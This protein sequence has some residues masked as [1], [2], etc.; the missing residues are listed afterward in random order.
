[1]NE[2]LKKRLRGIQDGLMAH[3]Q[4]TSSLPTAAIG[5]EREVLVREF[6]EKVFPP[7]YR[8]GSGAITDAD[9]LISGQLDI[10]I[11]WPFFAS[12]PG[13]M[14]TQRLYLAESVAF[15]IEVKSDLGSQWEQVENSVQKLRL[16]RRHWRTH[17]ALDSGGADFAFRSATSS[18]IPY[19]VVGFKGYQSAMRLKD[20][21]QATEESKR[22]DL[23]LVIESGAY[24]GWRVSAA[25]G[26]EGLFAFCEECSFLARNVLIAEPDLAKYVTGTMSGT[27]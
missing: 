13:P 9:G 16:L 1:M 12:F 15:V 23:A 3:H 11:E 18:R 19:V 5:N 22:P 27:Q 26:E 20:R 8:F 17:I 2:Q 21:L 25:E 4:A 10:V 14:G 24:V 7:P 6:L